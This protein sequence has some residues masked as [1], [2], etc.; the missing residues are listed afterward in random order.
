MDRYPKLGEGCDDPRTLLD[1]V[2]TL[3]AFADQVAQG[4]RRLEAS[5]AAMA[6][7]EQTAALG[8]EEMERLAAFKRRAI[9]GPEDRPPAAPLAAD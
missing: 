3:A 8:E 9:L 4:L 1:H 5:V 7:A 2:Q 6:A